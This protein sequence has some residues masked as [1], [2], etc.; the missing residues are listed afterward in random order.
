DAGWSGVRLDD[1]V[2]Y[3]LHVGA[4]TDAGTFD[5]AIERFGDL[6]DLGVTAVELMPVATFPG[7]FG[8]GYD[9]LYVSAPHPVYGGPE[10]LA[11]LVDAAQAA[12]LR[13]VLDVVYTHY[14]PG[15]E[16]LTACAPYTDPSRQT[17]WGPAV[18][19]SQRGV[20]EWAIQNAEQWVRDYHLDGL[21]LDAVHAISDDSTPHVVAELADRVR[22]VR[23][24]TLVIAEMET[25]DVRPIREWDCDAQW[26]D[27]LHHA[28]HVLVTGEREGYY[29][30][31]GAVVDVAREYERADA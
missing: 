15:N 13:V 23:D 31:Y 1:L 30:G 11:R 4:F 12:G 21:R 7:R 24:T 9:G 29:A 20:R 19:F 10:G 22:A 28:V 8:W 2:L 17:F 25:G 26:G 5:A 14:G 27:E 18:A 6:V 3:E 16:A